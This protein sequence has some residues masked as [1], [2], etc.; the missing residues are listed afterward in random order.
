MA[1]ICDSLNPL[2]IEHLLGKPK[3]RIKRVG[4]ELEGAWENLPPGVVLEHDGS[5]FHN[6]RP[7]GY[8]VGEL[9]LVRMQPAQLRTAI[10]KYYPHKIDET[11]GMHVH[12]SFEMIRH[13]SLLM[14]PEYPDT[15]IYFLHKWALDSDLPKRHPIWE[16]LAGNSIFCQK[17]FWPEE[18]IRNAEKDHDKRRIGH[19]YTVINYCWRNGTIECRV[20]PMMSNAELAISAIKMVLDI[21]NACL[22]VLGKYKE[23]CVK[24]RV[25]VAED[26]EEYFT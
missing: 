17:K 15:I 9:P 18:Q 2:K 19:R 13:Y 3:N 6:N 21:T 14:V 12:M 4:V 23:I 22:I 26:Y 20:L 7:M 11:C 1:N 8:K 24:N 5:V 25:E 16:R 10:S